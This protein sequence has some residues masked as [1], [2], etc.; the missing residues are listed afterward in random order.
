MARV[1]SVEPERFPIAGAF[2]ISRGSKTE[3]EV[4]TVTIAHEGHIGRGECVP[5]RRYGETMEGVREAIEAMRPRLA[6]GMDR[7]ALLTAMPA[8]AARNAIDCALWDLEAKLSG[9][10][11]ATR[12]CAAQPHALETAYTLSLGEPEAMAA[13]ARANATRPLL[14]VKIGGDNDLARIR[15]V[16]EAAPRSRIILDAN[17][18]WTDGNIEA[19]L[20][21]AAQLGIALIEQPLPAGRDGILREIAHP[22]PICADESVHEAKDLDSL[23]GLYDAVNIKLDKSGGLTE[24]VK[25]NERARELGFGIMVGCMVGTSL[26]MAPAVLLAQDA[27]FVD[28]DGPLLLARDREPGLVYQGSLVSPPDRGLWG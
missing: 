20:A 11:V 2:T 18:G 23:V 8:G 25:L 28:L 13:Q 1:I 17:E 7:A 22:V 19:N 26:A 3:A 9:R 15:A 14:K 21:F 16:T 4:I 5:Y 6:G 10:P 24:A 12:I 27:D